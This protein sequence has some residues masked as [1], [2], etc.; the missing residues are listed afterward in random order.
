VQDAAVDDYGLPEQQV[1]VST[2]PDDLRG[3]AEDEDA[4]ALLFS[5][6]HDEWVLSPA[7]VL[8]LQ[9]YD[10]EGRLHSG[11]K[12]TVVEERSFP[13][14]RSPVYREPDAP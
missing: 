6:G 1:F 4:W 12:A 9:V 2:V 11:I 3:Q 8:W 5:E 14:G 7:G 10:E 13:T